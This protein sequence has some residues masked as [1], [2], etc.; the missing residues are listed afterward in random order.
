M[1]KVK[2]ITH[3]SR[4]KYCMSESSAGSLPSESS[5]PHDDLMAPDA[6]YTER[7]NDTLFNDAVTDATH[8]CFL[9]YL[10][11]IEE[12]KADR[13]PGGGTQIFFGRYVSPRFSKVRGS[14]TD[15]LP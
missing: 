5:S 3:P 11:S 15:F 6:L 13:V 4:L 9:F 10:W 2:N 1:K 8:C 7:K 12:G 14:G